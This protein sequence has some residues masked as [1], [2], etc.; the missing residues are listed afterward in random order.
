DGPGAWAMTIRTKGLAVVLAFPLLLIGGGVVAAF[1]HR[2]DGYGLFVFLGCAGLM[3]T[4]NCP[5]CRRNVFL[6]K[7]KVCKVS[8]PCSTP[9]VPKACVNCGCALDE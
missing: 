6:G 3:L 9:L 2:A 5:R 1:D 4:L 8:L 7:V